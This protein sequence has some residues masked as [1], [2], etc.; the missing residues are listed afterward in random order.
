MMKKAFL[1]LFSLYSAVSFSQRINEYEFVIVPIKFQF[2]RSENEYRLNALLKNR[3]EDFGF[4][5]FYQAEQFNTNYVDPCSCLY[6]DV[7]NVSNIFLTKLQVEFK[8]CTNGI[9]YQSS[10]GTSEEKD[11]HESFNEALIMALK[12]VRYMNYKFNGI[13]T[14][15]SH[16]E[17]VNT[18][19][20]ILAKVKKP[21]AGNYNVEQGE[22][23]KVKA[24]LVMTQ[25]KLEQAKSESAKIEQA[26]MSQGKTN[27]VA[28][29]KAKVAPFRS[30]PRKTAQKEVEQ[31]KKEQTRIEATNSQVIRE[32]AQIELE[33]AKQA[34]VAV[35]QV[36][37]QQSVKN[38]KT[39]SSEDGTSSKMAKTAVIGESLLYA[40]PIENGF[41][42]INE[43]SK[44][45][46]VLIKTLQA[47]YFT[48][49]L[50][51]KYGVVF[52]KNNQWVF[53]YYFEGK[54]IAEDLNI[55]F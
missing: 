18:A 2:Q 1:I 3:L 55:E 14:D 48:A 28:I 31:A 32:E 11:R 43:T 10:I 41:Q 51:K 17:Q 23:A 50:D 36:D 21:I 42:L 33:K 47:D 20:A 54:L 46:L 38:R 12:S 25:L 13:K 53:E 45:V 49:N 22:I 44:V 19:N 9:V 4:R 52:K 34:K 7:L 30:D 26:K 40:T 6:V 39:A 15:L 5:A 27:Q 37:M 24:E 8:D 16:M 29:Q 35:A